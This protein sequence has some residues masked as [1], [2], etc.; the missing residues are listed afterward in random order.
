VTETTFVFDGAKLH[1]VYVYE[2]PIQ[3]ADS[4]LVSDGRVRSLDKHR[5]RFNSSVEKLSSL[6]LDAFWNEAVR[7][8]P[9]EGQFFPRIELSGDNLVLR[10]REPAEFKPTVTL[11]TADEA[12]ERLDSTTKGPD[13]AYGAM[14][15]R[16]SNLHGA[17][18]AVIL[19][20]D[21]FLCEGALSSL[22]W[23]RDDVLYAPDERTD[24]LPSV[25]RLEV[26]ELADQAGYQTGTEQVK[27]DDLVGLEIWVLSSLSGIRPVVDWVNLSGSVGPQRHL[28]SF[29]RRLKLMASEL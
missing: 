13:L 15:R 26:F 9:R 29:Q 8:I 17:D 25:T 16:K 23:W 18:E 14:L 12:D 2:H 27:P 19:N 4:F 5:S 20:Q 10:L 3:V 22:V 6:D 7:L 1:L 24:W 11:W 28:E 21:G